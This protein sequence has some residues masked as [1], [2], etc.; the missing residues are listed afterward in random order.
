MIELLALTITLE[1][2]HIL[3]GITIVSYIIWWFI[4]PP[5]ICS[6]QYIALPDPTGLILFLKRKH[7]MEYYGLYL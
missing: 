7:V 1:V 2:W 5:S 3:L 6:G 4:S